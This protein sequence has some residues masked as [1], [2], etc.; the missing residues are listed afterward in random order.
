LPRGKFIMRFL[1][2]PGGKSK[3]ISFLVNYLPKGDK[4]KGKYIEPFVAESLCILYSIFLQQERA[5]K[6]LKKRTQI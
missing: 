4:I 1:R 6:G 2:Y 5:L 3:L